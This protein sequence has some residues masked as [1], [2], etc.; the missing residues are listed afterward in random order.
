M[1]KKT[2]QQIIDDLALEKREEQYLRMEKYLNKIASQS[3]E[4]V[5]W[6]DAGVRCRHLAKI[7]LGLAPEI[8]LAKS[9]Q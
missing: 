6:S 8:G 3:E 1:R 4:M 5:S 2:K 7:G 9:T